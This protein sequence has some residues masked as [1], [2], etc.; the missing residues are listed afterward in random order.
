M[1]KYKLAKTKDKKCKCGKIA[2]IQQY[3][4]KPECMDCNFKRKKKEGIW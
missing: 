3:F 2:T 1:K 4:H